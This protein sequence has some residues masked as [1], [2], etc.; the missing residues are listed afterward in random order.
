M[1]LPP[2]ATRLK[3]WFARRRGTSSDRDYRVF[4]TAFDEILEPDDLTALHRS[5]SAEEKQSFD[6]AKT[7]FEALFHG[8]R[9]EIAASGAAL[10]RALRNDFSAEE[11]ARTVVS[12]LID[13]SGSMRGLRMIS[14]VLAVEGAVD[15]LAHAGIATEILGFTTATWKGGR[16]RQAWLSAGR[17]P[18][19]GRLCDLRHIV[20]G[21]ADR[22]G[23]LPWHLRL[24]LIPDLLHENID[25]EALLWA[26]GRLAPDRWGHRII[27]LVS[28]GAPVDDSTLH[29]NADRSLLVRHLEHS[30]RRLI[31]EGYTVGTLLIG[32]EHGREPALFERAVEPQEAGIA[33]L[34]L[35]RRAIEG[36]NTSQ[37]GGAR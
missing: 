29:A 22:S 11:R 36:A 8:Q 18:N 35:I 27:C 28:D 24:A 31:A 33:L 14:A 20:Y 4:T 3:T 37:Q 15:A 30:E 17:P 19:P 9:V 26:A 16:S 2:F 6:E 23:L 21:A 10:V 5:L 12:L 13:H 1:M 7:R 32:G 25:G 34:R